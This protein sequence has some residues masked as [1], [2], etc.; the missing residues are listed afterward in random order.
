VGSALLQA[1]GLCF[2]ISTLALAASLA[3]HGALPL[4]ATGTSLP[5]VR[6]ALA[7]IAF[8]RWLRARVRLEAFRVCFFVGLLV[9]GGELPW[10]G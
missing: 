6:P 10:G 5:A 3:L 4:A 2:T 1:L 8:G 9:L 7:G